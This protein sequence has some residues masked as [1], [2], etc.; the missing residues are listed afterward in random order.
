MLIVA[1]FFNMIIFY[2]QSIRYVDNKAINGEYE[3]YGIVSFGSVRVL[4]IRI[5]SLFNIYLS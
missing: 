5:L 3:R 1:I 4:F 2:A